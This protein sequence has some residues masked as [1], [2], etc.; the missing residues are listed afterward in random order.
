MSAASFL[1]SS[2]LQVISAVMLWPVH[3]QKVPQASKHLCPARRD[4]C[5]AY[6]SVCSFI[7]SYSG[8]TR[9][10]DPQKSFQPKIV[11]CCVLVWAAYPR[12][13]LCRRFIEFVRMIVYVIYLSRRE[14]SL[15]IACVT[16]STSMVRP[17]VMTLYAPLSSCPVLRSCLTVNHQPDRSLVT[18]PS[19]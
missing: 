1:H 13:P 3:A 6:H 17:E 8:M 10:I 12:L 2:V 7:P 9:A 16:A 15:C 11:N 5:C 18:E 19:M 14:A 4:V